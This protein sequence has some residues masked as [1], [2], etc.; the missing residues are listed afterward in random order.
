MSNASLKLRFA[1]ALAALL[2]LA[3]S[4]GCKG[5]FV[6]QPNSL[7]VTQN[8]QSTL[9]VTVGTPAQL[10]A[11]ATYNSGN[12]DV[13]N[14]A[15][16]SSSSAC[17]TVSSKGLVTGVGAASGVTIT[18]T[19]AGVSGS[20]TGSVTGGTSQTLTIAPTSAL[21]SSGTQQFTATDSNNVNQANS[22]TWTSGNTSILT[23][24][25]TTPG[26]ATLL[27]TGTTTVS[28]SLTS[29]SSCSSGSASV[30]VQ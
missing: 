7:G 22:A 8:S 19:V 9:S 11:T 27:T 2:M 1:T 5:F 25:T 10:T 30:T 15:S 13:T 20:I 4:G 3:V 6:N 28:A 12:K 24:S 29:G 17:A 16:W 18:A 14:S 23:F 26:L 21:L